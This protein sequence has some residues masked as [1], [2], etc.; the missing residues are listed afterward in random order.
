MA[1]NPGVG[2]IDGISRDGKRALLSRVKSRGDNNLYLLDL[3]SG[4]DTLITKHD[5]VA[6]F[7]GELAPDGGAVYIGTNK[8][9]DLMAL[10]RIKFA[11]DGTPGNIEILAQNPDGELDGV[12]LNEQGTM[13]ALLWNV[14]GKTKLSLYDPARNKQM[15]VT[16]TAGRAGRRSRFLE[17]RIQA[18]HEYCRRGA[19]HR[20]LDHGREDPAVSPAYFQSASGSGPG[21]A[22]AAGAG[23]VQVL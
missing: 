22:G 3:A 2:N 15:P 9:R 7:F 6:I 10:G 1:K 8:D 16:E 4:K 17:G 20:H 18:G 5:G 12:R 23:D 21:G 19:A 13:A 14:K 11:A